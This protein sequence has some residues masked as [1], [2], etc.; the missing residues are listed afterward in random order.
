MEGRFNSK[1]EKVTYTID[2]CRRN[3][4]AYR[5]DREYSNSFQ[6]E[7]KMGKSEKERWQSS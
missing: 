5:G 2:H 3:K 7:A 4:L 6:I 1:K